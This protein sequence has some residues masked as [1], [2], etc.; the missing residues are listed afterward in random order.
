[1]TGALLESGPSSDPD[2]NPPS[3]LTMLRSLHASDHHRDGLANH[4]SDFNDAE[5]RVRFDM[6]RQALENLDNLELEDD[7]DKEC[8]EEA[9]QDPALARARAQEAIDWHPFKN[10]ERQS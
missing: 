9:P 5:D 7:E 6:L 2:P 1:M 4:A 8:E 10:K 3:P